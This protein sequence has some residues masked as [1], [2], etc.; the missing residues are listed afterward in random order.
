M[1]TDDKRL[2]AFA[3][4]LEERDKGN[5]F[6]FVVFHQKEKKSLAVPV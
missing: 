6:P 5:Q 1:S 3:R 2:I 4:A